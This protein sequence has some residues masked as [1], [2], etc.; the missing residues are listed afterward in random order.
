V[1]LRRLLH[2]DPAA[3]EFKLVF[4]A[5]A[6]NDKEVAVQTRS[7]LQLLATMAADVEVP[8]Q[9]LAEHSAT[10][11]WESLTSAQEAMRLIEIHS[12]KTNPPHAFVSVPYSDH[13]FWID[14]RDLK[15]KRVFSLMMMLFTLAD[16]GEAAAAPLVTIPAH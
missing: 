7:I 9:D 3:S 16:T 1:E 8:A 4:G 2:L 15:S 12:S 10:P 14:R 13:W 11:G 6:A 5:T